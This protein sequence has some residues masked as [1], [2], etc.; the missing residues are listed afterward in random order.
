M[1]YCTIMRFTSFVIRSCNERINLHSEAHRPCTLRSLP[2]TLLLAAVVIP[3]LFKLC[4][5]CLVLSRHISEMADKRI[6]LTLVCHEFRLMIYC[7][8]MRFT[9]F[10]I[11][12]CNER[13]NLHCVYSYLYYI[14]LVKKIIK[15]LY[16]FY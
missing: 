14:I 8:I 13:I 7:T 10:V 16:K 12:S 5:A 2:E 11:R 15:F 9:S 4:N 3:K 1:I 6:F